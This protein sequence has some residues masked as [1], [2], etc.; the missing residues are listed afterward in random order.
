MWWDDVD[1]AEVKAEDHYR[2]QLK[3]EA[4][5]KEL[6]YDSV[7]E[8]EQIQEEINDPEKFYMVERSFY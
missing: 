6:G 2:K 8:Y 1:E 7:D 3:Y 5:V 4:M